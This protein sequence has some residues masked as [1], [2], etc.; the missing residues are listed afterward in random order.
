MG[1]LVEALR[2][3]GVEAW[4]IDISEYAIEHVHESIRDYCAVNSAIDELA[5]NFPS[6]FDLVTCIEVIE[7]MPRDQALPAVT[8][9]ARWGRRVLFSSSPD[10]YTEATHLNVQP[11]EEWSA[12]FAQAGMLRDL[13]LDASFLTNWAAV[14]DH[15]PMTLHSVV[16]SYDRALSRRS[17]EVN[18]VRAAIIRLQE[19]FAGLERAN[20]EATAHH[21]AV[22]REAKELADQQAAELAG[23]EPVLGRDLDRARDSARALRCGYP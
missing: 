15:Q 12:L 7:H 21:A 14:Y 17:R 18:E 22:E 11:P 4:G 8:N 3:R 10:D 5:P 20:E 1:F 13:D 23:R 16:R 2:E 19:T 9:L 6:S